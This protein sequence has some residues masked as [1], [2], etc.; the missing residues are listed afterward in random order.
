MSTEWIFICSHYNK[1]VKESDPWHW[2]NLPSF[3]ICNKIIPKRAGK[4]PSSSPFLSIKWDLICIMRKN[5]NKLVVFQS[6]FYKASAWSLI[7][8]EKSGRFFLALLE[9]EALDG[10]LSS[11]PLPGECG[12]DVLNPCAASPG[13]GR[14]IQRFPGWGTGGSHLHTGN[15]LVSPKCASYRGTT[16]EPLCLYGSSSLTASGLIPHKHLGEVQ[17][18]YSKKGKKKTKQG[19]R[20]GSGV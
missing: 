17:D 19:K 11:Q 15:L 14:E 2:R 8:P 6:I 5:T 7:L 10:A 4:K 3:D 16:P 18:Y 20:V 13:E 12:G 1:L 9:G